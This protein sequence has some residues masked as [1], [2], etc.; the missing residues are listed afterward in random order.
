[1]YPATLNGKNRVF[2]DPEI[3]NIGLHRRGDEEDDNLY[4]N[5]CQ[6]ENELNNDNNR[7]EDPEDNIYCNL[8]PSTPPFGQSPVRG[9]TH[10]R[11]NSNI[12]NHTLTKE[13]N[14]LALSQHSL[15]GIGK[16]DFVLHH[17]QGFSS[18]SH[19]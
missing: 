14:T 1:M 9:Q 6:L 10:K 4:V 15:N 12:S 17:K 7:Y 5:Q 8:N 19:Q 16:S 18:D 11:Q 3:S 2:S 13:N